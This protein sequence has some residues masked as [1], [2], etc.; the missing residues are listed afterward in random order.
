MK[1][2]YPLIKEIREQNQ[3]KTQMKKVLIPIQVMKEELYSGS[4]EFPE[5]LAGGQSSTIQKMIETIKKLPIS[6][7]LIFIFILLLVENSY[8]GLILLF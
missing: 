8:I 1:K 2:Q 5:D 3:M 6:C 7:C 4:G